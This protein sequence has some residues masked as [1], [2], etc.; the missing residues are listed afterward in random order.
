MIFESKRIEINPKS[1]TYRD[2]NKKLEELKKSFLWNLKP[3]TELVQVIEDAEIPCVETING[4]TYTSKIGTVKTKITFKGFNCKY[5][6]EETFKHCGLKDK[7]YVYP[8]FNHKRYV[9]K[10]EQY[11]TTCFRAWFDD[12]HGRTFFLSQIEENRAYFN[13]S[14]AARSPFHNAYLELPKEK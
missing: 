2:V 3:G 5:T 13:F 1:M 6:L 7:K 8:F 11:L 12:N 14:D 10:V 4:V 9:T